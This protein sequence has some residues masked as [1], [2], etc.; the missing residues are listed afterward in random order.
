MFDHLSQGAAGVF[1]MN[2]GQFTRDADLS[3]SATHLGQLLQGLQ[4]AEGGFIEDGRIRIFRHGLQLGLTAFLMRQK[5]LKN[6]LLRWQTRVDQSW[7]ESRRAR[8]A[9]HLDATLHAL[10]HQQ[11]T[12]VGDGRRT[13]ICHQGQGLPC[14]D[15]LGDAFHHLMLVTDV[16]GRHGLADF[17]MPQQVARGTCILSQ[18]AVHFLQDTDGSQGDILEVANRCRHKIE[19]RHGRDYSNLRETK[20]LSFR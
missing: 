6:E 4:E 20:S 14:L 10:A 2:L 11:E 5:A 18:D 8:Q 16:E 13:C 9:L 19:L 3:F 12:R 1:L 15:A 17:Q 7:N